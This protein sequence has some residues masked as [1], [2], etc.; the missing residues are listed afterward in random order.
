MQNQDVG[1]LIQKDEI[2]ILVDLCGHTAHNRL[3][4][5]AARPAPIIASYLGYPATS[6]IP[7]VGFR[8]TD[9]VVDPPGKTDEWHTEKLVRLDRCAWCFEAPASSPL[10]GPL[11]ATKNGFITFGCFNNLAKLNAPLYDLWVEIL[12]QVPDSRLFLKAKTLVDPAICQEVIGYFTTRGIALDRLRVSGFEAVA[13]NHFERYNEVDMALDSYPYHGTTTTCEAL[14]MGVPVITQAGE[15]HLSR[16]GASLLG[17]VG[18]PELVASSA[19][20]YI[21]KAVELAGDMQRLD[22]LRQSLRGEMQASP[23]LDKIGFGRAI[24]KA[25][26]AMMTANS[27]QHGG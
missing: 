7:G 4:V 18:H 2:D 11:P 17:A 3:A 22:A 6:G 10:V 5:M 9:A 27:S 24:E 1:E 25:F 15:A 23:L 19:K 13:Q 8:I 21:R 12:Q 14:W 20:E 16:V 26:H